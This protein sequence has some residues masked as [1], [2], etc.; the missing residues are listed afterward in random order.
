M[1]IEKDDHGGH[2][3]SILVPPD[4]MHRK[5][6][7]KVP[8]VKTGNPF[9]SWLWDLFR[10]GPNPF[11]ASPIATAIDRR[12]KI[13]RQARLAAK[14]GTESGEAIL[15]QI[16]AALA[17]YLRGSA[18]DADRELDELDRHTDEEKDFLEN[19][20]PSAI[21]AGLEFEL[22]KIETDVSAEL[23][24]AA[25]VLARRRVALENFIA[26]NGIERTIW[27]GKPL[28]HQ[29]IY[30]IMGITLFE[31]A[32]N[33]AFFSGSQRSG[34]IGGAA[35]AM[36]LSITTIVLGVA[37]GI[38]YQFSHPKSE[39]HGWFGRIGAFF[40]LLW[41]I[42]YLL[43]LTLARLAGEAG[44]THMFA[45]AARE[46]QVHPFSGLLDLPALAYFFF[47]IAVIAGIFYKFIDTMG[48]YPRIRSH[49]L[50]VD[51]AE[52]EFESTRMGMIE[53]ARQATDD[54]IRA[55]DAAPNIIQATIRAIRDLVMNYEN[56][57]DQFKNDVHDIKDASRLLAGVLR[58]HVVV[59]ET[60]RENLDFDTEIQ[61][62]DARLAAFQARA[63]GL[64][65]WEEINP[66][67]IEKCR[68]DMAN[69]GKSELALIEARCDEVGR[70]RY[71]EAGGK[72]V[73]IRMTGDVDHVSSVALGI[74]Q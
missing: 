19:C 35:L 15:T 28:T 49:K 57:V 16:D 52:Y 17:R 71:S 1:G 72:G 50:A 70:E 58:Q 45:A 32:L 8:I 21:K 2:S 66:A 27:W 59:D 60:C 6:Y 5:R 64:Q 14:S 63:A 29:S 4:R 68:A 24:P 39:G 56:V 20:R 7:S 38:S 13:E 3:V 30:L 62:I 33:T 25:T 37:F 18:D 26:D 41:T 43:L 51:K 11:L 40:L 74:S 42:Y 34:I 23:G 44:D 22:D 61:K 46:I 9:I 67:K 31:F 10:G 53:A 36:L 55:L 12:L 48:H 47:S 69:F 73:P 65:E 54:S